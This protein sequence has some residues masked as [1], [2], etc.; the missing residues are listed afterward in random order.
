MRQSGSVGKS[1]R[2]ERAAAPGLTEGDPGP[3]GPG[4]AAGAGHQHPGG[5]GSAAPWA[6]SRCR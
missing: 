4:A 1:P 5:I 2:V 6:T 3:G